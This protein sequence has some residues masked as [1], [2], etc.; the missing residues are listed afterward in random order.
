MLPEIIQESGVPSEYVVRVIETF[1]LKIGKHLNDRKRVVLR[2]LGTFTVQDQMNILPKITFNPS[3]DLKKLI[4]MRAEMNK[5][6]V[7]LDKNKAMT[8]KLTRKCPDCKTDLETVDPPKCP[9]CGTRPFEETSDA[10][11]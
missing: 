10:Q 3:W 11:G 8:A 5:Y 2:Y 7:V 1:C 9:Q 4:E 6:S